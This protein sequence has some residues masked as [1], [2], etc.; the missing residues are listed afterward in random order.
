MVDF[1]CHYWIV[2]FILL[3]M[4]VSRIIFRIFTKDYKS[5]VGEIVD[6]HTERY[7]LRNHTYYSHK[8][9]VEFYVEGKKYRCVKKAFYNS[10]VSDWQRSLIK[11]S[12]RDYVKVRYDPKDPRKSYCLYSLKDFKYNTIMFIPLVVAI[13]VILI[14][15]SFYK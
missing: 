9:I 1:L 3:I 6:F 5:T 4:I 12:Y 2:I 7:I 13:I 15:F 10:S 14:I 8:P 11:S